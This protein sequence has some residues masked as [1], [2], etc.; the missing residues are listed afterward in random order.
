MALFFD[1][2]WV[3]AKLAELK[4]DRGGL[5]AA[6]G[7]SRDDLALIFTNQREA[8]GAEIA[9]FAA[10]LQTELVEMSLRCGIAAREAAAADAN[11]TARLD[12]LSARLDAIDTWLAEFERET[13]KTGSGD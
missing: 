13:R 5:A 9:A 11:P 7:L 2:A 3:D 8:T 4:L 10:F 6:A 12:Q 1:A